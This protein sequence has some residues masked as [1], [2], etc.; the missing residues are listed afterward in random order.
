MTKQLAALPLAALLPAAAAAPKKPIIGHL[1]PDFSL[2]LL[3][4]TVIT[5][6]DLRGRVVMLN[7]WATWCVPCRTELPLL[8]TY[9]KLRKD[10]GLSVY[11]ITTEGSVPLYQ[12]KKFLTALDMP[13]ARSVKGPYGPIGGS[14]PTN[15]V[16]GRDG[17]LH[18]A[19]AGAF[20][21]DDL[22]RLLPP[23]LNQRV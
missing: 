4:D 15:F 17:T 10:V 18:Y 13:S 23:L 5:S 7:F 21:L 14:V 22:N 20:E 3:D 11:A 16:I 9:H 19:K 1:A 2:K 8:N 6:A 12:L